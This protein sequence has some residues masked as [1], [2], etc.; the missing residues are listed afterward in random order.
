MKARPEKKYLIVALLGIVLT[1]RAAPPLHAELAEG[2]S[3][4][5]IPSLKDTDGRAFGISDLK[6]QYTILVFFSIYSDKS[7]E[8]INYMADLQ[9]RQPSASGF[10][11]IGV[12]LD[13]SPD[14]VKN[15]IS[16]NHIPFRVL[17]DLSLELSDRFAV[18]NPPSIFIID[19]NLVVKFSTEKFDSKTRSVL[20][21][22]IEEL[23]E[24]AS[25]M[26]QQPEDEAD[27]T[28]KEFRKKKLVSAGARLAKFC[29]VK[30][31]KLLYISQDNILWIFDVRKMARRE[32]AS[33]ASSAD[34]S[35][36][37]D[38][39]VY[40]GAEKSGIWISGP[41][42]KPEQVAPQGERPVWSAAGDLI[43][44]MAGEAV[45][46]YQRSTDKRWQVAAS[47]T[48]VQWS[49]D[50]ALLLVTDEKSRIWLISPFS[51]AS[52]IERILK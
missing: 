25:K 3:V 32:I 20:E 34:W 43:A 18:K 9:Q 36:K 14:A 31:E 10:Q 33:D 24:T 30:G 29:S 15:Y 17:L 11:V 52:L 51:Q 42:D 4:A 27:R 7:K 46:V 45:W 23:T 37:C 1:S 28:D 49:S 12:N 16:E 21:S 6:G 22:R 38:E 44:F 19:P 26:P 47:G 35:P 48:K 41:E 13:P 5:S 2:K 40:S 8:L 39:V 50:G